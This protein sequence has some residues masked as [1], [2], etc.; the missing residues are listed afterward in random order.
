MLRTFSGHSK[1]VRD[2]CYSNDGRTFLSASYDRWVKHWDTETGECIGR[3]TNRKTPYCVKFNPDE[4]KQTQFIAGCSDKKI[5]QVLRRT[6]LDSTRVTHTSLT[7]NSLMQNE[8][9]NTSGICEPT[10]SF[11]STTATSAP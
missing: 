3:Y 9:T 4:D 7:F 6:L 2:I 10:K 1:G 8:H 11:K 5:I